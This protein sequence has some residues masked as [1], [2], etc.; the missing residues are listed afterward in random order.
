MH[1]PAAVGMH[2]AAVNVPTVPPPVIG[3]ENDKLNNGT[4]RMAGN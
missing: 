2:S 4:L 1:S 3:N